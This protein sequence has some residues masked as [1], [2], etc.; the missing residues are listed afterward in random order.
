MKGVKY[1]L[2]IAMLKFSNLKNSFPQ[3]QVW[4]DFTN[5]SVLKT[6]QLFGNLKTPPVIN[7]YVLTDP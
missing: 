3:K 7:N 6:T 1:K 4:A 2:H 5:T